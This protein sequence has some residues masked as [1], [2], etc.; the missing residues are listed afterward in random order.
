[1]TPA[2]VDRI[3]T[4]QDSA[5]QLVLQL[6]SE[7]ISITRDTIKLVREARSALPKRRRY[8]DALI[9]RIHDSLESDN[10]LARRLRDEGI[11]ISREM[12][13]QIRRR[14]VYADLAP[15]EQRDT[16]RS[17]CDCIHWRSAEA[18]EPCDLGYPDPIQ[19]GQA[20]ARIC[21]T[22]KKAPA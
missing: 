11:S 15:S 2:L 9:R 19:E 14:E 21:N 1:M 17:C 3:V 16:G 13:R 4:S 20:F 5:R 18:I 12:I 10:H 6:R 7:G 8:D 22:Y